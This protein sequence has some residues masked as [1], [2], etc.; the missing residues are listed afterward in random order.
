MKNEIE[1]GYEFE[2]REEE[3]LKRL[4]RQPELLERFRSI[5]ELTENGDGPLKTADQMEEGLIQAL[6]QLG[7]TSMSQWAIRAEARVSDE[8]KNSDA[9][10]RSRK[11]K[12]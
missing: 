6:R 9:T 7:H 5:L 3:F 8:T 1:D 12:H 11:K 2:L 4:R 10:V